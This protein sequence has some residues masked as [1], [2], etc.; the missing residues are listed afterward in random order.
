MSDKIT[1]DDL[2]KL[3]ANHLK[4]TALQS[5]PEQKIYVTEADGSVTVQAINGLYDIFQNLIE[6]YQI[7]PKRMRRPKVTQEIL[8]LKQVMQALQPFRTNA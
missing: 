7:I 4:G 2:Q 6:I 1:Q 3:L 5:L 8:K